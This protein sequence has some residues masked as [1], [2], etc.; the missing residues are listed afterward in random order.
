MEYPKVDANAELEKIFVEV[1]NN[2]T[3]GVIHDIT[4][5]WIAVLL[6]CLVVIGA[7]IIKD[8]I[9]PEWWENRDEKRLRR[10][11]EAMGLN[12]EKFKKK[13]NFENARRTWSKHGRDLS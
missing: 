5:V 1:L 10:N 13:E 3:G 11:A 2:L 9:V 8:I 7:N 12:W 4:T 6:M